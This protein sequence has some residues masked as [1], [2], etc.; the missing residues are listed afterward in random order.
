MPLIPSSWLPRLAAGIGFVAFCLGVQARRNA[1]RNVEPVIGHAALGVTVRRMFSHNVQY[2]LSL[3]ARRPRNFR[4]E[5]HELG[6]WQH[7]A[8]ALAGGRGCLLGDAHGV[9]L[10]HL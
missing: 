8:E 4:L 1:S 2:Y 3:F 6:G 7:F 5:D 9:F 10:C